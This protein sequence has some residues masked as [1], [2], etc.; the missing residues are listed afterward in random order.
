MMV[1]SVEPMQ[2]A[3]ARSAAQ[4]IATETYPGSVVRLI[5]WKLGPEGVRNAAWHL[6]WNESV[7]AVISY[8][9]QRDEGQRWQLTYKDGLSAT[10]VRKNVS[11]TGGGALVVAT[12]TMPYHDGNWANAKWAGN[13]R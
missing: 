4:L 10:S 11:V 3:T 13:D 8:D 12:T 9:A 5:S 1:T 7:R 2:S 6:L